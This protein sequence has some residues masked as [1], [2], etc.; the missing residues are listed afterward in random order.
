MKARRRYIAGLASVASW[1]FSARLRLRRSA[2]LPPVKMYSAEVEVVGRGRGGY[3]LPLVLLVAFIGILFGFGRLLIFRYQC[4]F[5]FR[6][7]HEIERIMATRSALRW[8]ETRR[9]EPPDGTTSFVY[10]AASG[11]MIDVT[12]RPMPSIYPAPGNINHLDIA[13]GQDPGAPNVMMTSTHATMQPGFVVGVQQ[14]FDLKI[15]SG[16]ITGQTGTVT[17]DMVGLGS[18]L[19][20]VYGRRYWVQPESVNPPAGE[21]CDVFRL[22]ITPFHGD[23]H[24]T[25]VPAIWIEHVPTGVSSA[26]TKLWSRLPGEPPTLADTCTLAP[27]TTRTDGKGIQLAGTTVA[28]FRWTQPAGPFG[29]YDLSDGGNLPPEL[30]EAFNDSDI[31]LT[32]EVEALVPEVSDNTFRWIRVDPA[33]EYTVELGW[34]ALRTGSPTGE[35]ATVVH[36][37][38]FDD[39]LGTVGKAF[40]YDTHGTTAK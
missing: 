30:V 20:D 21:P 9:P 33:Y 2:I 19:N 16:G 32:L 34:N 13:S 31:T 17:I 7:Q 3:I 27:E 1:V 6:R 25:N 14:P 22:Y 36:L 40:T 24:D 35:V 10:R 37:Q 26:E 23:P 18:W 11:R 28:L 8:L 5:R 39:E 38:P 4:E 15:G 12:V 29:S